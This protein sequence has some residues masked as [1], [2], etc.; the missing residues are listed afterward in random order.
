MPINTE[1]NGYKHAIERVELV[2][3]FNEGSDAV[4]A[5]GE[6]YLPRPT[7]QTDGE[8]KAYKMRGYVVPATNPTATAI[9]GAIMRRPP[10]FDLSGNVSYLQDDYDGMGSN[11]DTFTSYMISEL[12]LA[13][14]LGYL[15]EFDGLQFS[16]KP[17]IKESIINFSNDYIVLAQSYTEQD[18]KDRYVQHT[19]TEYLELT[20]DEDGFYIQNIWRETKQGWAIVQTY[21]PTNRGERLGY[22]PFVFCTRPHKH[23]GSSDPFLLDLVTINLDQYRLSTD[24]RHGLHWVAL[25]TMFLFGDLRD[26]QGQ[27]SAITVGVGSANHIEDTDARAQLLEFTGAGLGAIKEAIADDIETMA[28]IGATMLSN[29]GEGVKAAE[30]ARIEASSE[31][32]TLSNL[33]N[34]VDAT[35]MQINEFISMWSGVTLPDYKVNRDFIDIKLDPA[36][37]S[38]L[39]K[40]WQSGGMSLNS[41][42]YQLQKGELLPPNVTPE[43]EEE[44]IETGTVN[45]EE[46]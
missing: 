1:Y 6:K 2:R 31:T 28:N 42:L 29:G 18:E 17:Y 24:Q 44:R 25:P 36:E 39:L 38:A 22:I 9:T 26:E 34:I 23:I 46:D 8:Y 4:K 45:F 5:K 10:T 13:G 40:T 7:G 19:K 21:Q 12:L 3:N 41:F 32:A 30:T 14:G 33:A 43:D 20:F 16:A 11:V 15:V 37:L 27:K 35:M